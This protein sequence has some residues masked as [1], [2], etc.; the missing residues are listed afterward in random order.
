MEKNNGLENSWGN[1]VVS[2]TSRDGNKDDRH[3]V[4]GFCLNHAPDLDG[5]STSG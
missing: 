1:G 3:G 4:N 2:C 5:Y